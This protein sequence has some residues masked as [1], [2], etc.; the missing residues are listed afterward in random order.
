M[1]PAITTFRDRAIDYLVDRATPRGTRP[2]IANP[3]QGGPDQEYALATLLGVSTLPTPA[4]YETTIKGLPAAGFCRDLVANACASMMI[5]AQVFNGADEEQPRP[6]ILESPNTLID[7]F[8]FWWQ[9]FASLL[10]HGNYVA[11]PADFD[12]NGYA[13]Q[14]LPVP[15]GLVNVDQSSGLPWYNVAGIRDPYPHDEIIHVAAKRPIG[16]YWG[17]GVVAQYRRQWSVQ[18]HQQ[19]YELNSHATGAIPSAVVTLDVNKVEKDVA[20][21]VQTDWIDAHGAGNRKPAVVPRTMKIEPLSWSP[22]DAQFIQARQLSIGECA[23]MFGLQPSDIGAVIAS[24]GSTLT[25]ENLSVRQLA[26]L[27]DSYSPW[28][29]RVERAWSRLTPGAMKVRGNPEALQRMSTKER[30]ELRQLAQSIGIETPEESREAEHR[31]PA[32]A[33][34]APEPEIDP[35]VDEPLEDQ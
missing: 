28:V 32:P 6:P 19:S 3:V 15:V 35:E 12:E 23:Y 11:I 21:Q 34:R 13:R 22:E 9:V 33:P 5:E 17:E 25:Y 7:E 4:V 2:A 29:Q 26:R 20:T 1:H 14:A 27:I 24:G 10:M 8:D 16:S 18:L 30:Y 31:P